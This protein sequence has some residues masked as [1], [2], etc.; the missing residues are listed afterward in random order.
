MHR[1]ILVLGVLLLSGGVEC[2]HELDTLGKPCSNAADCQ[3]GQVCGPSGRCEA[4]GVTVDS[5]QDSAPPDAP[6]ADQPKALDGHKGEGSLPDSSKGDGP[7]PDKG[8]PPDGPG[9]DA[10]HVDANQP[11]ASQPDAPLPDLALPD[12]PLPDKAI[13]PDITLPDSLQPDMK[14]PFCGDNKKNG[15][16]ECDGADLGGKTCA[17][18]QF[19]GTKPGCTQCKLDW[20]YCSTPSYITVTPVPYYMAA[21]KN[22]PCRQT[23][24]S[25]HQVTLT[26]KFEMMENETT[27][28]NLLTFMGYN[29]AK[30][31]GSTARPVEWVNWHEAVAFCNLGSTIHGITSCYTCSG[32]TA[33]VT[34]ATKAQY[35]G[36][37]IYDCPGYRLPT[38]AEWEF[39]YRAGTTTS[40]HKGT[41]TNCTGKDSAADAAGWY[42]ENA[43]KTT[44][45]IGVY[46]NSWGL[47]DMAGNVWEWCQDWWVPNLPTT[48]VTDPA[49]PT[50]GAKK[51][52]RGG[53]YKNHALAIRASTRGPHPTTSRFDEVGFRCVRLRK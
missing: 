30:H 28:N 39:A 16:E 48:P 35:E 47:K 4:Q 26:H 34:C 13:P 7:A 46:Y 5:G 40:T 22:D 32:T 12:A 45:N 31:T 43:G 33:N 38:E 50:S 3:L 49:G 42:L 8:I 24:E 1:R 6:I 41:I 51:V 21:P 20:A 10:F 2:S 9:K 37:K 27:Q 15:A 53:S 17:S 36:G 19:T 25:F 52:M 44:L 29:P 14:K 18:A 23:N 11:D